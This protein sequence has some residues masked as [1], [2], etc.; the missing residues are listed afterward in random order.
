[1]LSL[2]KRFRELIVVALLLVYPFLQFLARGRSERQPSWFDRGILAV[3]SPLE[4]GLTWVFGGAAHTAQSYVLLRGATDRNVHLERDVA[5]LR[6]QLGALEETRL[7][8]ERLKRMVGWGE[9]KPFLRIPARVVGVNPVATLLSV[10]IDKGEQEGVGRGMPV[11]TADGVVGEVF[12]TTGGYADVLLLVDGK[13]RIGVRIARSRARGTASGAAGAKSLRLENDGALMLENV[14]RSEDVQE[15][16]Q[17]ITSGTDGIFPP[18]LLVGKT[19]AVKRKPL[20]MFLYA[21]VLP[22]VDL[23]KVE[24]VLVLANRGSPEPGRSP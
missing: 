18:G 16:D 2:L 5:S 10:R 19:A 24:E 22:A 11:V 4:A 9:D 20:G 7:E 1:M 15:G 21:E 6:E 3:A 14:L 13:S 12:R 23:N 8:N 17:V